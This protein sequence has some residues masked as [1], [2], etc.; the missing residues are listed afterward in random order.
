V[1]GKKST[2]FGVVTLTP[3]GKKV[4][5][6]R[7]RPHIMEQREREFLP[8]V[9]AIPV[10][11]TVS[12]PNYDEIFHNVF[13]TGGAKAFDLGL[14]KGG[15]A[16]DM[17]FDKEGIIRV[18]CNIHA[19]MSGYIVVVAA[20]HYVLTDQGGNFRFASLA[21][22]KYTL[23]AWTERSDK[24]IEQVVVIKAGDNTVQVGLGEGAE[25]PL[26]DKFGVARGKRP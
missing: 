3:L 21:P 13:S 2:G 18:G 9:L 12:F 17:T 22:G 24:P 5:P 4:R 14:Y 7:P 16:R 1:G 26:P 23:R 15:Q 8:H 10:G 19:N 20:P 25:G 11:S 6:R